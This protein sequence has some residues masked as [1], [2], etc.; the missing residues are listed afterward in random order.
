MCP[1]PYDG[2]SMKFSVTASDLI[3]ALGTCNEIAPLKSVVADEMTGVLIR[4]LEDSV[5]FMASDDGTATS[6]SVEIPAKIEER[7]EALVRANPAHAAVQA[8]YQEEGFDGEPNWVTLETTSKNSLKTT[9][10]NRVREGKNHPTYRNFT[11]L[12]AGFFVETPNFDDSKLTQVP[13]FSFLDG[14]TKVAYAAEKDSSKVHMSC[15]NLTLTDEEVVFAATNGIQIAEF[16]QAAEVKGLRGSFILGLK[17]ASVAPR[18]VNPNKFEFVDIYVEDEKFFFKQGGT[19]L[20]SSL[21][22]AKFPDYSRYMDTEG[23]QR[24]VFPR[25]DFSSV[26]AGMQPSVDVKSH[27][28]MLRATTDGA[29]TLSTSNSNGEAE[30]SGLDVNTPEEFD[31]DFDATLLQGAVR[32]LKGESFDFYFK[33]SAPGVVV[34]ST[35]QDGFKAF[36]CTLKKLG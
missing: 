8:S 20:V 28:I 11:L 26:L 19:V 36:L 1:G 3:R 23:L 12:N 29:A 14:L 34:H 17:F 4:T 7:G 9:G 21:V 31:F 24:A 25:E 18:L 13:S 2:E 16:R 10:V 6:V 15:I 32:Q 33:P 22:D 5:V 30:S 27:R 35:K